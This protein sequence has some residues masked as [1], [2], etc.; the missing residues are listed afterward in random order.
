MKCTS[1]IEH[2]VLTKMSSTVNDQ[3]DSMME[4]SDQQSKANAKKKNI[5]LS[6]VS[7][8]YRCLEY[9]HGKGERRKES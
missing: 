5:N 4:K 9:A 3:Q 1:S 8:L 7:G 2:Q 6:F